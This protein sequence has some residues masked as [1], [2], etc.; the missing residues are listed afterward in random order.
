MSD[1]R[2]IVLKLSVR[3]AEIVKRELE[4]MGA[5]GSAALARLDAA[6]KTAA[7]TGTGA[8]GGGFGGLRNVIGQAGFQI[9]DF[10]V[11]VQG[12]TS[13]LTA[14]SQQG[15][16]LLGVFGPAGA[17]AGAVLT[18]GILAARFLDL[19][20]ATERAEAAE[21]QYADA[22]ARSNGFLQTAI[23]RTQTLTNARRNTEVGNLTQDLDAQ[24]A[25]LRDIIDQRQAITGENNPSDAGAFNL[26]NIAEGDRRRLQNL[27]LDETI[28]RTRITELEER[29]RLT[30]E[31]ASGEERDQAEQLRRTLDER[32]RI[33]QEYEERVI[34]LRQL[35]SRSLF[36][37]AEVERSVADAAKKRDEE[38][39]ALA[40]R[41]ATGTTAGTPQ[42]LAATLDRLRRQ[43]DTEQT[44]GRNQFSAILGRSSPQENVLQQY[45]RDQ[46]RLRELVEKSII[47]ENEFTEAV[48][49]SSVAL[50]RNLREVEQRAQRADDVSRQ[51]GLTFTS[52]FED[53]ISKGKS[54]RD[55]L[56]GIASD[57][58]KLII[59]KSI[60][61][62]FGNAVSPLISSATSGIGEWFGGAFSS[63]FGGARAEGGPV[64]AG[65]PYMVGERGPELFVPNSSG[66]IVPNKAMGGGT[67]IQNTFTIDARG[68]GPREVDALRAQIPVI[69]RMA[70]EDA[71]RRGGS[72]AR[73]MRGT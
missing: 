3:D 1:S 20:G 35:A 43:V 23:Q 58:A 5:A 69:A 44:Q 49:A 71:V 73:T 41:G 42:S 33:R 2:A 48:E 65:V 53:A 12:G 40:R 66:G 18:V 59:R 60:T 34:Q 72:F 52:A 14:L 15:S 68:A 4:N 25:R 29:A 62:P 8:G 37:Q 30:A 16:Q 46:E 57:I 17:I 9:Q 50:G 10:A 6:A 32:Y 67:V 22:L 21:K 26:A 13:A 61:E 51:L 31:G 36:S 54:F 27:A 56:A 19:G 63:I 38:L 70:V 47:T 24:R 11:Q 28:L 45:A 55:V 39:A 64:M 7:G